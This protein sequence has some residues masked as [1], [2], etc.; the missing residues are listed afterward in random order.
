MSAHAIGEV[1]ACNGNE[2]E[3][4]SLE[5]DFDDGGA[6]DSA[7]DDVTMY[8]W[9]GMSVPSE[10]AAKF[11]PFA[12]STASVVGEIEV[13]TRDEWNTRHGG[14]AAATDELLGRLQSFLSTVTDDQQPAM[15]ECW[16][17]E[18]EDLSA[19]AIVRILSTDEF[20]E[21]MSWI[22]GGTRCDWR[23]KEILSGQCI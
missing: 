22:E 23:D 10:F 12:A 20:G 16:G 2:E 1:E 11:G 8:D 17:V 7:A 19:D 3:F 6:G 13:L 21:L 18:A 5:V 9:S 4:T 14:P 15:E